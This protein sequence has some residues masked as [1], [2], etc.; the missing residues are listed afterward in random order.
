[1]RNQHRHIYR[2]VHEVGEAG[3]AH[4]LFREPSAQLALRSVHAG[5][6]DAEMAPACGAIQPDSALWPDFPRRDVKRQRNR[7]VVAEFPRALG[8]HRGARLIQHLAIP[9]TTELGPA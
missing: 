5:G 9:K 1:M 4:S 2:H 3:A 7:N 8:I 6:S